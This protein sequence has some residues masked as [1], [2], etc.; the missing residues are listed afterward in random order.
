MEIQ[1]HIDMENEETR[2]LLKKC[3]GTP[4]VL[5]PHSEN[6]SYTPSSHTVERV[7]TA[8]SELELLFFSANFPILLIF[9]I[10]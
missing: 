3:L 8:H 2:R 1:T 4:E 10:V 6:H 7:L 5:K 9:G